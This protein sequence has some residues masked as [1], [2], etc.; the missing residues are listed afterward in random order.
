MILD[1]F[2]ISQVEAMNSA[3]TMDIDFAEAILR[4]EVRF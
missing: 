4:V 1:V 3:M 2:R